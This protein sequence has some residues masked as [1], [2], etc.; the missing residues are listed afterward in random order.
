MKV[1]R[2][3]LLTT[4]IVLLPGVMNA[5]RVNSEPGIPQNSQSC[6]PS[7]TISEV[8]YLGKFQGD[9]NVRVLW[10]AGG[11]CLSP[12]NQQFEVTV[13]LIRKLGH[14]DLAGVVHKFNGPQQNT[15]VIIPRGPLETDPEKYE[16]A[17]RGFVESTLATDMAPKEA[18]YAEASAPT[19]KT[20]SVAQSAAP[21]DVTSSVTSITYKGRA[22]G[23]DKVEIKGSVSSSCVKPTSSATNLTIVT[24]AAGQPEKQTGFVT[25][26]MHSITAE[27][28]P[29]NTTFIK[30][31]EVPVVPTTAGD[32]IIRFKV[33]LTGRGSARHLISGSKFANF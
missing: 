16:V 21:C 32:P 28:A 22:G 6:D 4:V 2:I 31:L 24:Q 25:N 7:I 30:L 26:V 9:D 5:E 29:F 33:Q 11:G 19:G 18:T 27:S 13:R 12:Q 20:F 10:T 23:K 14:V 3:L 15:L 1:C 8:R 17:I